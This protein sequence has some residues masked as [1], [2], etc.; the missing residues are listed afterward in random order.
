[1]VALFT[2]QSTSKYQFSQDLK[3]LTIT[4]VCK[5][6][7]TGPNDMYVIQCNATNIYGYTFGN[8]YINVYGLYEN[9]WLSCRMCFSTC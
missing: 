1:M 5:N 9:L 7:C 8:G 6:N 3:Q 2:A 4:N